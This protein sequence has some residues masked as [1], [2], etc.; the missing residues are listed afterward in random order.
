MNEIEKKLRACAGMLMN[1]K[2]PVGLTEEIALPA[3]AVY[4]TIVEV[5]HD[6]EAMDKAPESAEEQK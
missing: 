1:M 4:N 5:L 2:V 3:K 6:L